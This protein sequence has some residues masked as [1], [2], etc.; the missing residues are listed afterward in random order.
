VPLYSNVFERL[1]R[2]A[3]LMN[4]QGTAGQRSCIEFYPGRQVTRN[5]QPFTELPQFEPARETVYEGEP[6]LQRRALENMYE[7]RY[8]VPPSFIPADKIQVLG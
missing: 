2:L 6:S 7:W 5:G 4:D 8:E 3:K 1:E